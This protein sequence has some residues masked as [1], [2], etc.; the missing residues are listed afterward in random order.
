[1]D[2]AGSV[3][4]LASEL[5]ALKKA[6]GSSF[7]QLSEKTHY[8]KSSW[9]RWVNGKQFPPRDAVERLARLCDT[10][11]APLLA[12]WAEE[13]ARRAAPESEAGAGAESEAGAESG[14]ETPRKRRVQWASLVLALLLGVGAISYA[15][16]SGSD[17]PPAAPR[18]KPVVTVAGPATG[19]TL[20]ACEGRDPKKMNCGADAVTVRTGSIPKDLVI[21]LRYSR[22]CR[23]AWGRISF[24]QVGATVVVNNSDGAAQADV[25]HYD[26]D[27]YTP[28]IA[29]PDNG[30]V[31]VCAALPKDVRRSCTGRFIPSEEKAQQP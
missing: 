19:C 10:D 9:E 18:P 24:A 5:L 11:P 21:E 31:W 2:R 29:A 15:A 8:A 26:R 7:V 28:L 27:V 12:L 13:D 25:V 20:T 14:P 30:S 3:K 4:D 16:L 1:M 23:A 22:A 17:E 6:S